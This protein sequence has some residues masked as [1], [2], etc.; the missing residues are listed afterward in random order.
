M[1]ADRP[2]P[3]SEPLLGLIGIVGVCELPLVSLASIIY[4]W[5]AYARG[6][7]RTAVVAALVPFLNILIGAMFLG[8]LL[9]E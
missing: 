1:F 7:R 8:L 4:S 2:T 3:E 6:S 5:V 9:A